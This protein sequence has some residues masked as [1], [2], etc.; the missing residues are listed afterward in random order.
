M[1]ADPDPAFDAFKRAVSLAKGQIRLAEICGC[2]QSNI[3]QLLRRRSR[4]P[5]QFVLR[6]EA[7]T[8]VP[9]HE[10]RPDLYPP[11]TADVACHRHDGMKAARA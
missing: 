6:T 1:S 2:T 7:A 5:G 4:L 11:E 3:S 8:G 10:L 9:R